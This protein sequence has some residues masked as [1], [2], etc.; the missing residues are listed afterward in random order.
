MAQG[1]NESG[2]K[3][4]TRCGVCAVDS[5]FLFCIARLNADD[6]EWMGGKTVSRQYLSL[7]EISRKM[8][9]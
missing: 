9:E 3:F 7:I 2:V 4:T 8:L 6:D 1:E 5:H